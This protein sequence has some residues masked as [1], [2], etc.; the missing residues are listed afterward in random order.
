[1]LSDSKYAPLFFSRWWERYKDGFANN[2]LLTSYSVMILE[3]SHVH[4][5]ST[6]VGEK[7][8]Y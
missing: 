2:P 6:S 8:L 3:A 4:S 5:R 1:M 7:L